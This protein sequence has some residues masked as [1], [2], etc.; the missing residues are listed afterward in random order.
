MVAV[1]VLMVVVSCACAQETPPKNP[2]QM[3]SGP[4]VLAQAPAPP[5]QTKTG[6]SQ[7]EMEAAAAAINEANTRAKAAEA[8]SAELQKQLSELQAKYRKQVA[9][10]TIAGSNSPRYRKMMRRASA[11]ARRISILEARIQHGETGGRASKWAVPAVEQSLSSGNVAGMVGDKPN[12]TVN[13]KFWRKKVD[14]QQLAV[15]MARL[16]DH[17][18]NKIVSAVTTHNNA[19]DAHPNIQEAIVGESAARE[20]GDSVLR[21]WGIIIACVLAVMAAIG[22]ILPRQRRE[23]EYIAREIPD[24]GPLQR[25][26]YPPYQQEPQPQPQPGL[27]EEE[28]IDLGEEPD[29]RSE[30]EVPTLPPPPPAPEPVEVP[31]PHVRRPLWQQ[32]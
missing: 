1:I 20:D 23:R 28:E 15:A 9:Q 3:S 8:N 25:P 2:A 14:N 5:A 18:D 13:S 32:Q 27:Y 30:V 31:A 29:V 7:A 4:V 6:Y 26:Q 11:T 16:R 17:A 10:A 12:T 22:W 24:D 19:E 21:L